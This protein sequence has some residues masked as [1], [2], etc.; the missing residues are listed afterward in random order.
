MNS[1]PTLNDIIEWDIPNWSVALEYWKKNTI[2]NLSSVHALEIGSKHGGLSLWAA[3]NGMN[4]LC[5]DIGSPSSKAIEK[6]RRYGVA[7]L[8]KYEVLNALYIPYSEMFQVVFLK[9]VLG[10][11][12]DHAKAIEEIYKSLSKGGELWFAENL[13]GSPL[14]RFLRK[15][16]VQWGNT[17]RCVTIHELLECFSMFSTFSYK[18]VG[19]LGALGRSPFQR[20][21]LGMIDR[22]IAD[23]MVP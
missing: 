3:L 8:I 9:S 11:V 17:W 14:H 10:G 18:T 23:K 12:G 19:F 22:I 21:V 15:R 13:A 20:R 6:H 5:T 1:T 2:H 4:V 16:Y 7:H